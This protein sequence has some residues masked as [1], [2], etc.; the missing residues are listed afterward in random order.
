MSTAGFF[1]RLVLCV[2]VGVSAAYGQ[3]QAPQAIPTYSLEAF[4]VNGIPIPGAPVQSVAV[5]PKDIIT[6][7][8]MLR[9]WSPNGEKLR[10]YQVKLDDATY[11]S[12]DVG[13]VQPVDFQMNPDKDPNA[14]IDESDPTWVHRG[15]PTIP[16]VDSVSLGYRW[17]SVLLDPYDGPVSDQD[18]KKYSCGT[19]K[20]TPSPNATGTFTVGFVEDPFTSSVISTESV[21]LEP[22]NFERLTVKVSPEAKWRRLLSSDPPSGAVDAR[23]AGKGDSWDKIRLTF[24]CDSAGL[25]PEDLVVEDGSPNPPKVKRLDAAGSEV[26]VELD[27]PI[28]AGGWTTL[29]HKAS[30]T[31]TRIGSFPG[32]VNGDGRADSEDVLTMIRALNGS[33]TLPLHR[34]DV[35]HNG[36]LGAGDLL[37][38][39]E[40]V[41]ATG[42]ARTR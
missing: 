12:G 27:R 34:S 33:E 13:V 23:R 39:L 32:D 18:G 17:L 10:A 22:I 3:D 16:L 15:R 20:L 14:F 36:T 31:S 4:E 9:D 29:T 8:I 24:N 2:A 7:K 25:K 41:S 40:V 5:G 1:G 30:K 26:T 42:G 19:V 6:C 21:Q 11:A 28:R 37:A 38:V 35:D